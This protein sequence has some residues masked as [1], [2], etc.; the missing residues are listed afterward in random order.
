VFVFLCM[1][2]RAVLCCCVEFH[3]LL[4]IVCRVPFGVKGSGVELQGMR[5]VAT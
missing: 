3:R 5:L 1:F 2:V 4:Q